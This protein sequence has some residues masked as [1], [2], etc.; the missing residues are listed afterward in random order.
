[1]RKGSIRKFLVPAR[2]A[3]KLSARFPRIA[4][5]AD[6]QPFVYDS[7]PVRFEYD[8]LC[9]NAR[10]TVGI[11]LERL[12]GVQDYFLEEL[13]VLVEVDITLPMRRRGTLQFKEGLHF[14]A[15][16][17]NG[18]ESG[19]RRFPPKS[20]R[21]RGSR[22]W[23]DPGRPVVRFEGLELEAS[24][25]SARSLCI[26]YRLKGGYPEIIRGDTRKISRDGV[27]AKRFRWHGASVAEFIEANA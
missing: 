22:S 24:M 2:W 16:S 1:M 14:T 17:G 13:Y 11:E 5:M 8:R 3:R 19:I 15:G 7:I 10:L 26:G 25:Q 20:F 9:R 12:L 21:G 4:T 6:L 27:S 23:L 18:Q